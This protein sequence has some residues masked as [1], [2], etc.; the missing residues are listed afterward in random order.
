V[1]RGA[2]WT[3]TYHLQLTVAAVARPVRSSVVPLVVGAAERSWPWTAQTASARRSRQ[4]ASS[5]QASM[6]GRCPACGVHPSGSSSGM[7]LSSRPVSG[8]LVSS[9]SSVQPSG[10]RPS[11]PFPAVTGYDLMLWI[12]GSRAM[13]NRIRSV[14]YALPARCPSAPVT[15]RSARRAFCYRQAGEAP[16][17]PSTPGGVRTAT[18]I[19]D[20]GD[21]RPFGLRR[22]PGIRRPA[23]CP[24][25]HAA[26]VRPP[27]IS[28]PPLGGPR[29]PYGPRPNH[30]TGPDRVREPGHRPE[31]AHG[32]DPADN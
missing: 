8:P 7:R 23:A 2:S 28:R 5:G 29:Q 13:V 12:V 18:A 19:V 25:T 24:V 3:A 14:S 22:S 9:A 21:G 10:A 26:P 30:D 6:G 4:R 32:R 17:R 20:L 31:P 16:F 11:S 27:S 1:R 15:G